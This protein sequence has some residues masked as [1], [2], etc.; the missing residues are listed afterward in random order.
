MQLSIDY[1]TTYHYDIAD[2]QVIQALRLW[3]SPSY[4]Q[5]IR[6]WRVEVNG[7]R[8]RPTCMDGFGN[9]VATYSH[10]RQHDRLHL[11]IRGRVETHSASEPYD[12]GDD[13]LPPLFYR[14]ATPLT[15]CD[16]ALATLAGSLCG[17]GTP[18]AQL[19][20]L[21]QGLRAHLDYQPRRHRGELC[22][23]D[24]LASGHGDGG[25]HAQLFIAAARTRGFDARYVSGYRCAEDGQHAQPHAWAEV[26]LDGHGWIGFDTVADQAPD[27]SYLR[28]AHGRD[29]RD[30]APVRAVCPGRLAEPYEAEA[31][32]DG[33]G[34]PA[35]Q[36]Q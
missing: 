11:R 28:V 17:S 26:F 7:K 6:D 1:E 18:M 35:S 31:R 19:Q 14:A 16:E 10:D 23:T 4:H 13:I 27:E 24:I 22:A 25:E 15:R 8:V 12:G 9:P 33:H 30:A 2:E 5:E 21:G 36:A 20:R 3:P 32:E 34:G 29:A